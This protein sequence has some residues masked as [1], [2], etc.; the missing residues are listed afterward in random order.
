MKENYEYD[1]GNRVVLVVVAVAV[2]VAVAVEVMAGSF[3]CS[4]SFLCHFCT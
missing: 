2:A 4:Y 3:K 1:I